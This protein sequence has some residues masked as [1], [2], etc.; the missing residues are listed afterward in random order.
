[1]LEEN[2]IRRVPVVDEDGSICGI[3]AIADLVRYARAAVSA[4]V[5][6]EVSE[7][8]GGHAVRHS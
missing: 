4:D 7:P 5:I 3:V 2:H 6:R 1:V 8:V